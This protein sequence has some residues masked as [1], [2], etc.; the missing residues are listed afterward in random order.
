MIITTLHENEVKIL[1]RIKVAFEVE[2]NPVK[3]PVIPQQLAK[4]IR[5]NFSSIHRCYVK[6]LMLNCSSCKN[7]NDRVISHNGLT[8][9]R[10]SLLYLSIVIGSIYPC[11]I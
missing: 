3:L 7:E 1:P 2:W 8:L 10:I 9:C 5:K 11:V 6:L 4:I